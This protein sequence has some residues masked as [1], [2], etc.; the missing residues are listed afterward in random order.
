MGIYPDGFKSGINFALEPEQ[1]YIQVSLYSEFYGTI[2]CFPTFL[3]WLASFLISCYL[4][5]VLLTFY[6]ASVVF[7][8]IFYQLNQVV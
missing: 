8:I 6:V 3:S 2:K 5:K 1:A 4:S 7:L